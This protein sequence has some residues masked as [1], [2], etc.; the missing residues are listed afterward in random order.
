MNIQDWAKIAVLLFSE[1]EAYWN[2]VTGIAHDSKMLKALNLLICIIK[3][4]YESTIEY[5][6]YGTVRIVSSSSIRNTMNNELTYGVMNQ[7]VT[8]RKKKDRKEEQ[9]RYW[10]RQSLQSETALSKNSFQLNWNIW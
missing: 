4:T 6:C 2:I 3:N 10:Y 5:L 8:W 7:N 9:A 1:L